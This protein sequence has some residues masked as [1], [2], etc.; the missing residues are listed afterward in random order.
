LKSG[1]GFDGL[2]PIHMLEE[3][4]CQH[5]LERAVDGWLLAIVD[6]DP[7]AEVAG[8]FQSFLQHF[9]KLGIDVRED[10]LQRAQEGNIHIVEKL[11]GPRPRH[12]N[13]RTRRQ[14]HCGEH[15]SEDSRVRLR[16]TVP[17]HMTVEFGCSN[18]RNPC[19]TE[20]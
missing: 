15:F 14:S 17:C 18:D 12:Q 13:A 20:I 5:G 3:Q 8:A 4:R 9:E 1:E 10:D 2:R 11:A 6:L 19:P 16:L 7:G